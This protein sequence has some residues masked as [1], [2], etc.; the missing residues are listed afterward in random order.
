MCVLLLRLRLL[1]ALIQRISSLPRRRN[2]L[3]NPNLRKRFG[4]KEAILDPTE[5]S[6]GNPLNR[7]ISPQNQRGHRLWPPLGLAAAPVG[8]RGHRLEKMTR[9]ATGATPACLLE[10]G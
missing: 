1:L 4:Q 8:A 9:E 2:T 10:G 6:Q 5:E 3:P 7:K